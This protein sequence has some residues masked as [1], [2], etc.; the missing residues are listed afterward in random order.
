MNVK[1]AFQER[2]SELKFLITQV[3]C[4]SESKAVNNNTLGNA[5]T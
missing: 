2:L 1:V 5:R 4:A 3:T